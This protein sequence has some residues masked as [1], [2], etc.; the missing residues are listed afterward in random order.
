MTCKL[1]SL[2]SCGLKKYLQTF[3]NLACFCFALMMEQCHCQTLDNNDNHEATNSQAL[4]TVNSERH[5][6][7]GLRN[8]YPRRKPHTNLCFSSVTKASCRQYH[9]I[10]FSIVYGI[11]LL[12]SICFCACLQ[13][14]IIRVNS[15]STAE[16]MDC[17]LS[18]FEL[19]TLIRRSIAKSCAQFI[20][21]AFCWL[22]AELGFACGFNTI[23]P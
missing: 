22:D 1:E 9:G 12:G 20:C 6:W 8:C 11:Q 3:K 21:L 16:P 18:I 10:V 19:K 2:W 17:L 13:A 14:T 23:R 7:L 5:I 4:P 15:I